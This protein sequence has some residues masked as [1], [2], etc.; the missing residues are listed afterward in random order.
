ML[1]GRDESRVFLLIV[2]VTIEKNNNPAINPNLIVEN[3]WAIEMDI[4]KM[5]TRLRTT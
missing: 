3:S 5:G 1:Q 2:P 4:K